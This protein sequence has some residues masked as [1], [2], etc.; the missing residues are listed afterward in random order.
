MEKILLLVLPR[1]WL[2]CFD[3]W[4]VFDLLASQLH[5]ES[6]AVLM[7][8]T[9]RVWSDQDTAAEQ[10]RSQLAPLL[11]SAWRSLLLASEAPLAL[12]AQ[13]RDVL[14]CSRNGL[15]AAVGALFGPAV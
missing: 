10:P 8:L 11:G 6:V 14:G 4:A 1:D 3:R 5:E 15:T 9:E 2:V 13:S 12:Q 7:E